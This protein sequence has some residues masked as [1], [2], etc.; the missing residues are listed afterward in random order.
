MS[1]P[2]ICP[3]CE[4]ANAADA[5]HC[6][7][8][9][10]RLAPAAEGEV[11]SPE[12]NVSATLQADDAFGGAAMTGFSVDSYDDE[13]EE[14]DAPFDG[15]GMAMSFEVEESQPEESFPVEQEEFDLHSPSEE[16]DLAEVPIEAAVNDEDDLAEVPIEAAADDGDFDFSSEDEE[17]HAAA[18][19]VLYSPLDGQA[20]P[21]G[22][23]EFEEGFGPMGEELVA[24]PPVLAD[25]EGGDAV[26]GDGFEDA[27]QEDSGFEAP[28]F[29]HDD[30]FQTSPGEHTMAEDSV[31]DAPPGPARPVLVPLRKTARQDEHLAPLPTPS[32]FSEPATLTIYQNRQPV[33]TVAIDGDEMLIGRRDPVANAFPE[34]DLSEYD[35]EGSVSRKHAYIFRQ[36]KHY[37]LYVTSN[38]GTQINQ[39]LLSLGDRRELSDG[40][41][42]ILAGKLA[43]KFQIPEV[44]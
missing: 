3:I 2:I 32:V 35:G 7:V 26:E 43:M 22:T 13:E 10:E 39:D 19:A 24:E 20:Y 16:D 15:G 17:G 12:E 9:G 5:S 6:E 34:I 42:I 25:A 8:C 31:V 4:T 14:E 36:N 18:P 41:V 11:L 37:T 21:E 1:E 28:G 27:A 40:D 38:T 44:M 29:D 33:H 23:P 30:D